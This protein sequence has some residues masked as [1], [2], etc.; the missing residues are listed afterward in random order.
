MHD[1]HYFFDHAL[2]NLDEG[3]YRI[4]E[5]QWKA[6]IL[7]WFSREDVAKQHKEEFIEALIDFEDGCGDVYQYRAYFL[8]SVAL[9]HFKDCSLGDAIVGQLLKWG[10]IYFG[11]KTFPNVLGKAA[12][13]ALETTDRER[14]IST[15]AQLLHT[16]ESRFTLR[17]AAERLGRL[18]PAN[19][20]PHNI[21]LEARI[22][23]NHKIFRD[24]DIP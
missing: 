20:T 11:W 9:A 1:W 23:S 10:Y 6:E 14:V 7:H 3:T 17:H 8:A 16:T 13:A 5:P 21:L 24:A 15:F 22:S 4:F 2:H 12:R 19:K 18:D